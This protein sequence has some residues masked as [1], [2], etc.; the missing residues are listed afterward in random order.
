M[1]GKN[2]AQFSCSS[3][4]NEHYNSTKNFSESSRRNSAI[5]KFADI[6]CSGLKRRLQLMNSTAQSDNYADNC[7]LIATTLDPTFR[8]YW[9]EHSELI[10]QIHFKTFILTLKLIIGL[11]S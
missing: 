7:Y 6:L 11:P 8:F 9:I 3:H 2:T 10:V 5:K 4:L 1:R